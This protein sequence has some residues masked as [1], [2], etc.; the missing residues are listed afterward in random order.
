MFLKFCEFIINIIFFGEIR[1]D[2]ILLADESDEIFHS[3]IQKILSGG[4]LT[5]L[6]GH[7]HISQS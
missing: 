7:Q 3:Q 1:L 5:I 6:F 2:I 4:V